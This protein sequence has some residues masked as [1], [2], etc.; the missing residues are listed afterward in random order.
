[1]CVHHAVQRLRLRLCGLAAPP[2]SGYF[3]A[4]GGVR[5][6]FF[7]FLGLSQQRCLSFM[8]LLCGGQH[9]LFYTLRIDLLLTADVPYGCY[10]VALCDP[11]IHDPGIHEPSP[12][13][14]RREF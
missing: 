6:S 3:L 12:E 13:L 2:L 7:E 4:A 5:W 1:M 8:L 14:K 10:P 9:T 11:Q